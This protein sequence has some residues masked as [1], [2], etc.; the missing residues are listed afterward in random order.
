MR[1]VF[2]NTILKFET[3]FCS[4][5]S[6]PMFCSSCST[7]KSRPSDNSHTVNASKP[8]QDVCTSKIKESVTSTTG[9]NYEFI[10]NPVKKAFFE[11]TNSSSGSATVS[12]RSTNSPKPKQQVTFKDDDEILPTR[13]AVRYVCFSWNY[14]VR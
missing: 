4:R 10:Q 5:C 7:P 12:P 2:V 14:D 9:C 8:R 3:V 13:T 6:T 1:S 11:G